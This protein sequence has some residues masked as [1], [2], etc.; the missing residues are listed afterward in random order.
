MKQLITLLFCSIGI[1]TLN[2]Q[3][4]VQIP[5]KL[6]YKSVPV[7]RLQSLDD[8]QEN[9]K[10]PYKSADWIDIT[11][12]EIG[13]T[14]YDNQS[15]AS[16]PNRIYLY[17]DGTIGATWTRSMDET[18]FFPDRGTGYNYFNGSSW[19]NWPDSRIEDIQVHRP[20]Y[21][22]LG[23]NGELSVTHSSGNGLYFSSRPQKGTGSWNYSSFPGPPGEPYILWDRTVTSGTDHNRIHLLALTLPSTH[24]GTPYNGL[25]GALLYSLS[26]D[27]GNTWL[28]Q[29]DILPGMTSDEYTGFAGDTYTFAE[30]RGDVVAFVVG[31]PWT[32][33]FLMKSTDGGENFE[34]TV[35]WEHPYPMWQFGTPTDTFYCA[36]GSQSA[37]IDAQ[38]KVH[39][40]FG[41]NRVY[42]DDAGTY[43][44]PW[45]GGIGY[46][47]EDMDAFSDDLNALSPYG[48]PG[49]EMV[50]DVNLI[51]WTQDVDGNGQIQF[52]D[53]LGYYW[54]G[55]SSMPQ[56]V[57]DPVQN[58]LVLVFTSA[59]ETFTNGQQNYRHIWS[60]ISY[61][62]GVAN[63]WGDFQDL[64]SSIA[65]I[66][67]ECVYPSCAANT[68]NNVHLVY[69]YD[70]DPGIAS[71]GS[72]HPYVENTIGYISFPLIY[73]SVNDVRSNDPVV[74]QNYPNPF[75]GISTVMVK[76]TTTAELSLEVTNVAGQKVYEIPAKKVN[77]GTHL[78]KIDGSKLTKGIYFYTVKTGEK[79]ATKKMIV[80]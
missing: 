57:F 45:V 55:L 56:L 58:Y 66:F 77:A 12:T 9:L 46:W 23:E 6:R 67:D 24:G 5:D 34:K 19:D 7:D 29:N 79:S 25:D 14:R 76:L 28:M 52:A 3:S 17:D 48:D 75:A 18:N 74:S 36:D 54:L 78:L 65:H 13:D 15:N 40:A 26:D 33:L 32:G 4:R 49:S 70:I 73:T 47:N 53:E 71:W 68:D 8:A 60:R 30:P 59:T 69:Q 50:E 43:W 51:G 64:T 35:I 42:A 16:I 27:G 1:L 10:A 38:G 21:A 20:T 22:P 11:D 39:V 63:T 41:I 72:Q 61:G 62:D 2:A 37:C 44:Y 80:D 31:D